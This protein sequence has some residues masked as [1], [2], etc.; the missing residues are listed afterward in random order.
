MNVHANEVIMAFRV[1][2][3]G[4]GTVMYIFHVIPILAM[5]EMWITFV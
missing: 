5:K 2:I 3:Y 4:V 1:T